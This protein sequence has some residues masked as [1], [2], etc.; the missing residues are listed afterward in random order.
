MKNLYAGEKNRLQ[1]FLFF[2]FLTLVTSF[3]KAQQSTTVLPANGTS[4]QISSPQGGLRYQRGFYLI[5]AAEIKASGLTNGMAIN[6]IGFTIGAAQKDTTKGAFKVYL[7]NTTDTISR[8]DIGWTTATSPVTSYTVSSGLF[9][10]NYEWQVRAL[11]SSNSLFSPIN[12]FTNDN[13]PACSPPTNLTSSNIGSTTATLNWDAPAAMVSKYYIYYKLSDGSTIYLK[14]STINNSF[15]LTGLN[16]NKNYQWS[17]ITACS[18]SV[19]DSALANFTTASSNS[20]TPSPSGLA[21]NVIS[22]TSVALTFTAVAGA[23]YYNIQYRRVGTNFW[24]GTIAFTNSVTIKSGLVPG[25]SYEWQVN[26]VCTLGT[27][28]YISGPNFTTLGTIRCYP[29]E[30]LVVSSITNSSAILKWSATTGATSYEIRYRLKST[31]SWTNAITPLTA[32][33]LAL[34]DSLI[35]PKNIGPYDVKFSVGTSFPYTGNGVYVA[36]EYS[37]S[38]SLLTTNNSALSTNITKVLKGNTGLDSIIYPLSFIGKSDN[39]ATGLPTILTSTAYRPETRLGSSSLV[40]NVAVVAVYALGNRAPKFQPSAVV[41]ALI[42]NRSGTANTY[43]VILKVKEQLTGV[44]RSTIT[45]SVA[46]PKSD[47]AIIEFPGIVQDLNEN[48][49]LIVSINPLLGENVV[50]NNTNFY[51]QSVNSNIISY[52]DNS[53]A[54][55]SAGFNTNAGLALVR[56]TLIGCGKVIGAQ[57]YLSFSAKNQPFYA[58]A[59]DKTGAIVA[60]SSVFTPDSLA[61]NSYH[62]F[63][64]INPASFLNES[65]YIGLAQVAS[66]KGSYPVGTQWEGGVGRSR[67]TYTADLDGSKLTDS[68]KL[69]RLMIKAE[70][71]SSTPEPF[72]SGDLKLCTGASNTLTAGSYNTRFANSLVDFSSQ[73]SA[74]NFS[75]IQAL[76]TPNVFPVNNFSPNAWVSSSAD[77]Q[78][79][80]LELSFPNAAPINYIDIYETTNPGSVDTIYV[81]NPGTLNYDKVYTNTAVPALSGTG[82]NHITFATTTYNVNKVRIALN[83]VAVNGYN[84]IDAVGIGQSIVPASFSTYLW[85]PGN[86]TSGTKSISSPGI[87]TLTT[88]NSSGCKYSDI[89][90]VTAANTVAPVITA[91]R[92]TTFCQG[93]NVV[94]KS[95]QKGGNTWSTGATTDSI[96]VT[97]AGSYTVTYDDGSGCGPLTSAPTSVIVNALPVV[98]VSGIL[99]IC[100]GGSTTLDAGAGYTSYLWSTGAISE[101]ATI[102]SASTYTIKVINSN[103]CSGS[104]NVTTTAASVPNPV[105]TGMLQ[106]CPGGSTTLDAGAGYN[107]YSWS[108]GQTTRTISVSTVNTYTVTVTNASGCSGTASVSTSLLTP[109]APTITGALPI[110]PGGSVLISANTG[111]PGYLWST[112]ETTPSINV[113]TVKTYTVTVTAANGCKGAT[114]I[115]MTQATPPTPVIT[116][117]LSFCG[118]NSTV[119]DAG[120]DYNSYLWSNNVTTHS[121]TVTVAG[122][123]SVTVTDANGCTGSTSVTTTAQGAIPVTPSTISGSTGGVCNSIGNVYSISAVPNASFYVWTV[124]TGATITSGK[125]TTAITVSFG[126]TFTGGNIVV[127]AS[128]ACGQSPSNNPRTLAVQAAAATPGLISGQ[129]SGLCGLTAKVYTIAALNGASSYTWTVPTGATIT[130]GQGTT[131]ITINFAGN[132]SSGNICVNANSS[133]GNSASNCIAVTGLPATPNSITGLATVCSRQKN[134]TYSIAAVTGASSYTWTVPAQAIIV[135]GQGTNSIVV[136]FATK[137]GNVSVTANNACGLSVA[138]TLLV[139]IG[140]CTASVAKLNELFINSFPDQ[141]IKIYPNPTTGLVNINVENGKVEKY[142]VQVLDGAGRLV[143]QR[144]FVW[145]GNNIPADLRHLA[146]GIY[147]ITVFNTHYKKLL[148]LVIL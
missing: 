129:V 52:A 66:V 133:C 140:S 29:P 136:T 70:L 34:P 115:T 15:N 50:N 99:A 76:G 80:F 63:Y 128:N 49:S 73:Y 54:I 113:S 83:S 126:S 124:P 19:S 48:D 141:N 81:M 85:A 134:V 46:I 23:S 105:I 56:D 89:I 97:I 9:P 26:T 123:Y 107:S 101:Q 95:N 98:T 118:G 111:Y 58:V 42:A 61:V 143:Y 145:N 110:C 41:S 92:P 7:Q 11:C 139:T 53:A 28:S 30:N 13:L 17:V 130:S 64:F 122:S 148:K 69:G 125:S 37:Q 27:G 96:M 4:S 72:I 38:A 10:G 57:I 121:T 51:L 131:S 142:Q 47:S 65:F 31:I 71:I 112:N 3:A 62:S 86:E 147:S 43:N 88:T 36:W 35:I 90:N 12:N 102:T 40:D 137:S 1:F 117:T 108:N 78:R 120:L 106:F 22:D 16:P 59:L 60:K 87:Y 103:G 25:T 79:E 144:D 114:S 100:P 127:A 24:T 32:M 2:L 74:N 77:G 8:I 6:S 119:L 39:T 75:A 68:P 91:W 20:C 21:V 93:D 82:K 94:L 138:K 146:K 84:S 132:F 44:V 33:T 45:Q 116:G 109:P 135:S 5:T 18:A 104:A 14:D 67:A 55:S